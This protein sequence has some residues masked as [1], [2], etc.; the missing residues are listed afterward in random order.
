MRRLG[1]VE[2]EIAETAINLDERRHA[3]LHAAGIDL[4]EGTRHGGLR[5]ARDAR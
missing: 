1:I 3:E 4:G 2:D 5:T